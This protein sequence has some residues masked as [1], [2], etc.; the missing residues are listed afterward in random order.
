MNEPREEQTDL[1][2]D[3]LPAAVPHKRSHVSP[4]WVVPLLAVGLVGYLGYR[5]LASHGPSVTVT[6]KTAAGLRVE[7]TEVKYKSVTLGTV[8]GIELSDDADHVTVTIDMSAR[9]EPMLTTNASMWVVRPRLQTGGFSAL[10]TGLETL[11]SGA[12]IELDPGA[13]GGTKKTA[14]QGL[15]EPP[16]VR[17]G[18]PGTTF[19]LRAEE[20]GSLGVGSPVLHRQ[21]P[22]GEILGVDLSEETGAVSIR[23]FV[24]APS[25]KLVRSET[26]F[27]NA[28]GLDVGMG[29]SGLHV[30]V[31]SMRALLSG[32]VAFQTPR[33]AAGAPPVEAGHTFALLGSEAAA[34]TTLRGLTVPYLAYFSD[35]VQGLSV[36]SPVTMFGMQ[37]GS[38]TDLRL[39]LDPKAHKRLT[40]RVG[41]VLQPQRVLDE[42]AAH[43]LHPE[44]MRKQAAEGLRVLLETSSYVSGEKA[45][46]LS[47]VPD[48]PLGSLQEED[49]ALVLPSHTRGLAAMTDALSDVATRLN[50]IP[51]AEIGKT[52]QHALQGVDRVVGGPK[53]AHAVDEL[54]ATLEEVHKL[55]HEARTGLAPA[56]ERLPAIAGHVDEAVANANAALSSVAGEDGEF[57]RGAERALSQVADMARSVRLLAEFLERHPETLVRGRTP[58]EKP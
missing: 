47:Y 10:Q 23:A 11:V 36:G 45:L 56:L 43:V 6:F 42:Q 58:E 9:A 37:V 41:F 40:A 2:H 34:E 14:Y 21:V 49:G 28:S 8:R 5:A 13:P 25:D 51:F 22:V 12:Y 1:Q 16:T 38:V 26:C 57:L 48:A 24:R 15:E 55:A 52:L 35:S 39:V 53:V 33:E 20:V 30:E 44:A 18:E 17:S 32:G 29:A 7:Q 4:L 3:E 19:F 27:Y 46:S 50:A 54:S 31:A